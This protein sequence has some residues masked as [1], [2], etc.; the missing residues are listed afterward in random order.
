MASY[1]D[2]SITIPNSWGFT[3]LY[4]GTKRCLVLSHVRLMTNNDTDGPIVDKS[5]II[6]V[7]GIIDYKIYGKSVDI[8]EIKIL[9]NMNDVTSLPVILSKF[10]RMRVCQRVGPVEECFIQRDIA[11]RTSSNDWHHRL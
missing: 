1:K 2:L 4:R 3:E 8:H 7:D 5:V 6:D 11:Y 9:Q 10:E